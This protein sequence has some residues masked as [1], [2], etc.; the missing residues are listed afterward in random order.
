MAYDEY[1][2]K[3]SKPKVSDVI[4]ALQDQLDF[5]GDTRVS[6]RIEGEETSDEIQLDPY[7]NVLVLNLEEA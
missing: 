6:F 2:G 3:L 1:E 5:N 4:K 7:K